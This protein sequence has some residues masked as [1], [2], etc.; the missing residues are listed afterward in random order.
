MANSL[1]AEAK[2]VFDQQKDYQWTVKETNAQER[3]QKLLALKEGILAN[4][5]GIRH[6]LVS[7][8]R[9]SAPEVDAELNGVLGDIED[10]VA[11]LDI[12]MK[13]V[14]IEPSPHFQGTHA[15]MAYEPRGV[16][17]LFSAWNFPFL[18][19]FQPLVP[20]IAAGNCVI[21]KPNEMSPATS[22]VAAK[23]IREVFDEREVA[24]FEGG[25]EL[26]NELLELPFDHVFF[27]GSPRVGRAVMAAAA[28]HLASVTLELGGKCPAVVDQAS[29]IPLAA[30]N[31]GAGRC[32]NSGQVCLCPEVAWVR[33]DL[34]DEFVNQVRAVIENAYY[35]SGEINKDAFARI[36]DQRNF[37]RVR[38]YLDDAVKRGAKIRFGGK[39]E[40]ADLTIHPTVLTGVPPDAT[41]MSEEVFGP[42]LTVMSYR[43]PAEI[44]AFVR[45]GGKPLALYVFSKDKDFVERI[46]L[47]TSSGGVSVNG[48]AAHWF[49]PRLPFGGV[50]QSGIGRYHGI[51]GFKEMSHERSVLSIPVPA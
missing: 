14:E 22:R 29:D 3:K 25:I 40:A 41:I 27:T 51:H 13:P 7:D 20:A 36:V 21:A 18:L 4:A 6:A 39:T 24:V 16:C 31:I 49:E 44:A 35:V 1:S 45:Q 9:K 30:A 33:E 48:W 32:F 15:Y 11:N 50:N 10:A 17:L 46:L 47:Q 28:K 26:A 43:D 42:I 8:M 12:W 38:G 37:D 5:D 23:I 34:V 2:R 19:L